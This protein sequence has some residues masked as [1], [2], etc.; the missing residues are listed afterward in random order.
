[1]EL[2]TIR[3]ASRKNIFYL[4]AKGI[5]LTG[6]TFLSKV[7]VDLPEPIKE[8]KKNDPNAIYLYTGFHKSL[9]ETTGI[10]VNLSKNKIDI[11]AV[12]MGDNLIKGEFF[13]KIVRKLRIFL[14]KRGKTRADLIE[15]ARLLK[16]YILSYVANGLDVML[17]PEGTRKSIPTK[18]EYGAFF[19]TAFDAMLEYEK[20][21]DTITKNNDLPPYDT[22]IIPFNVDYSRVREATEMIREKNVPRTL[23]IWDS[24]K[25]LRHLKSIYVSYGEP[26]HVKDHL[27]KNRKELSVMV[28]N[29]CLE[30]VKIL[31]INIVATAVVEAFNNGKTNDLN[32]IYLHI[33]KTIEKLQ[34][35]KKNFREFSTNEGAESIYKKVISYE[36]LFKEPKEK[37]LSY[38][39]LYANYIGHYFDK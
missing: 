32:G 4:I 25:M 34:R 29:R 15:S 21:K 36:K 23:K 16:Q 30:L 14:I 12:G 22:Y 24:L 28:R 11:P 38:F 1:M 20:S 13:L 39:K 9:W 17:F 27:D 3:D 18:G 33:D 8:I 35:Y 6:Y 26:I 7:V 5:S 10:L 2:L 31:P 19:P 37:H